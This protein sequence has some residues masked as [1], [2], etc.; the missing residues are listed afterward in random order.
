DADG[1]TP[2]AKAFDQAGTNGIVHLAD[3]FKG[4][5]ATRADGPDRLVGNDDFMMLGSVRDRGSELGRNH[6]FGISGIA[7]D[8]GFADTDNRLK[9]GANGGFSFCADDFIGFAMV[10]APLGV[11]D[12]DILSARI[13]QHP[14][15]DVPGMGARSLSMAILPAGNDAA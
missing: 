9:S 10:G 2:L 5:R 8:L 4:R 6:R 13:S 11:A 12:N 7:L 15:R 3:F 14:G 1:L